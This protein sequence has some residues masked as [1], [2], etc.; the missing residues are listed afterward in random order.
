MSAHHPLVLWLHADQGHWGEI[1]DWRGLLNPSPVLPPSSLSLISSLTP[2]LSRHVW[3]FSPCLPLFL[4]QSH[5]MAGP[6]LVFI[7]LDFS[8][9]FPWGRVEA[10]QCSL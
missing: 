3:G 5:Y 9:V 1:G 2:A 4:S 7:E 8:S 6:G 10:L